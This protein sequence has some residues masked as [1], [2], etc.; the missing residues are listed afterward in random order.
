MPILEDI[1]FNYLNIEVGMS[2]I[3]YGYCN[4]CKKHLED[5]GDYVTKRGK[6]ICLKCLAIEESVPAEKQMLLDYIVEIFGFKNVPES[7]LI[8]I[9]KQV[10]M[11]RTYDGIRGTLYYF[12][13]IKENDIPLNIMSGIG[14]VEYVYDEAATY[15]KELEKT[16]DYNNS[17]EAKTETKIYQVSLPQKK[18]NNIDIGAL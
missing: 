7:W 12:Y 16:I 6:K 10:K 15:F 13:E 11:G 18:K 17:V 4:I 9:D 2:K 14:I 1:P 8:F 5:Y 3:E